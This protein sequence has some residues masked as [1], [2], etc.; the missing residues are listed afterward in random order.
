MTPAD[1]LRLSAASP[2]HKKFMPRLSSSTNIKHISALKLL[3]ILNI[4]F[5]RGFS[6]TSCHVCGVMSPRLIPTP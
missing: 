1:A 4:M 5:C 2:G 3:I 6:S